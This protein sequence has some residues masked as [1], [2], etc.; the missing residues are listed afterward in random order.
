MTKHAIGTAHTSIPTTAN[1][2]LLNSCVSLQ[3]DAREM[4]LGIMDK[5]GLIRTQEGTALLLTVHGV[6]EEVT[7]GDIGKMPLCNLAK[8]YTVTVGDRSTDA[9]FIRVSVANDSFHHL[10]QKLQCL[11]ARTFVELCDN[12]VWSC[13]IWLKLCAILE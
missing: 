12:S 7:M 4:V 11:Q 8:L 10:H 1:A 13:T 5:S 9:A 3:A 2:D 6:D